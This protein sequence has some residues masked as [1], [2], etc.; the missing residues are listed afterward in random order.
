MGDVADTLCDTVMPTNIQN[1]VGY[2]KIPRGC[3]FHWSDSVG[4]HSD[5]TSLLLCNSILALVTFHQNGHPAL[6]V[7]HVDY[8]V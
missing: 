3:D 5:K 1:V 8:T 2:R 7:S 6:E 4:A